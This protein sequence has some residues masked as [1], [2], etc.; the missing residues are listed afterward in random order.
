METPGKIADVL[1]LTNACF[2]ATGLVVSVIKAPKERELLV[3][4]FQSLHRVLEEIL[5]LAH[6]ESER[7]SPSE[8][9]RASRLEVLNKLI[10]RCGHE[11]KRLLPRLRGETVMEDLEAIP[12]GTLEAALGPLWIA[13]VRDTIRGVREI[14]GLLRTAMQVDELNVNLNVQEGVESVKEDVKEVKED[15][16]EVK[17][18]KEAVKELKEESNRNQEYQTGLMKTIID[19]MDASNNQAEGSSVETPTPQS[20]ENSAT[21]LTLPVA[22]PVEEHRGHLVFG[23]LRLIISF[24]FQRLFFRPLH[25]I[26]FFLFQWLVFHPL[27]FF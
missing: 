15:V 26:I 3:E 27:H 4:E 20:A 8:P 13:E 2:Q 24:F 18:V 23:P 5:K 22:L 6:E 10:N 21:E 9:R 25:L 12:D 17:E 7:T 14:T 11:M 19:R 1:A 16:K